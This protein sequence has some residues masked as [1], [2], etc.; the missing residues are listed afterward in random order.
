AEAGPAVIHVSYHPRLA[1]RQDINR[2]TDIDPRDA[3]KK[4]PNPKNFVNGDV[5]EDKF[6]PPYEM[7]GGK[8]EARIQCLADAGGYD[9]FRQAHTSQSAYNFPGNTK[10]GPPG[11]SQL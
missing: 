8:G 6:E 1:D 4:V 7:C 3:T 10:P 9:R 5:S 11:L 2:L